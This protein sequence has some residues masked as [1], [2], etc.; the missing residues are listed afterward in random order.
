MNCVEN[1]FGHCGKDV[2]VQVCWAFI[3]ACVTVNENFL[4]YIFAF[5]YFAIQC[6]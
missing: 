6:L 5:L 3:V 4:E 2:Q 1:Q